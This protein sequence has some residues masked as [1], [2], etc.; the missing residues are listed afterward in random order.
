MRRKHWLVILL[1]LLVLLPAGL[2]VTRNQW[3][4]FALKHVVLSRSHGQ[5]ALD[6]GQ[7]EVGV[8]SR[9]L[10]V[11][12]PKLRF[13]NVYFNKKVGTT[14]DQVTFQRLVLTNISLFDAVMHRQFFIEH[15]LLEKPAFILG[16][17]KGKTS[18]E[19]PSG[20]NPAVLIEAMQNHQMGHLHFAFLIQHTHIRFGRIQLNAKKSSD[21]HGHASYDISIENMGTVRKPGDTLHPLF[22]D[23]LELVVRDFHRFSVP[24]RLDIALDSA[25]YSTK[26]R[27]LFLNGLHIGLLNKNVKK[28]PV[29]SVLLRWAVIKGLETG[30]AKSGQKPFLRLDKCKVVGGE[31]V[32]HPGNRRPGKKNTPKW[33]K[34]LLASYH[35]LAVDT[36]DLRHLHIL[37]TDDKGDTT[38]A[39]RRLNFTLWKVWTDKQILKTF[40]PALHFGGMQT[41]LE[42]L[43]YGNRKSP[44]RMKSGKVFYDSRH[45]V[46]TVNG[47]RVV[48]RCADDSTL[49]SFYGAEKVQVGDLSAGMLQ[50]NQYQRLSVT[51]QTP[52]AKITSDTSCISLGPGFPGILKPLA[53]TRL[54]IQNGNFD[55]EKRRNYALGINGLTLFVDSLSGSK[56]TGPDA[57]LH[58]DSLFLAA[59]RSYF[60]S[61]S[62]NESFIT[63]NLHL[64]KK[65][66]KMAA[67][68][69]VR[70]DSTGYDSLRA[71]HVTFT[72]LRLNPLFFGRELHA[73]G[74]WFYQVDY[75]SSKQNKRDLSDAMIRK[76]WND[77][78]PV[79]LKTHIGY[80]RIQ[81]SRFSLASRS[82]K[83][84]L[85][86]NSQVD[87]KVRGFKMGYDTAHLISVPGHWQAVFK[88]MK[89]GKGKWSVSSD[90]VRLN[91]DSGTLTLQA[92]KLLRRADT[93]LQF[94]V[95]IPAVSFRSVRFA[96]LFCSD[97]LVFGNVVVRSPEGNVHFIDFV[98]DTTEKKLRR[99]FFVY[100]SIRI[101]NAQIS[102]Q[103][104]KKGEHSEWHISD[105]NLLYHPGM[106]QTDY[107]EKTRRNLIQRWDISIRQL[108]FSDRNRNYKM[109]ADRI[110]LQSNQN[111]FYVRKVIGTNFSPAMV[112]TDNKQVFTYFML[113]NMSLNQMTLDG[114]KSRFL[115]VKYWDMPSVWVNII[116]N[117]DT[118]KRKSLDFL[119]AGFFDKYTRF[120]GGIHVDSSVF[121][122]VNVSYQYQRMSKL[123]NIEQL[124][125]HTRDIQLGRPFLPGTS[126][127]L[128]GEMFINL[129][130]RAI[131]SG[132]SLYTFRMGDV[133]INLPQRRIVFDSITLTPRFNRD[134]FFRRIGY[135]ADRITLYGKNAVLDN[136]RSADLLNGHF[137]HF[138]TLQVNNMSLRFERDKHYPRREA[139][140]PMLIGLINRIPY[141]FRIDSVQLNNNM[142]SYFEYEVKSKNPAIFFIDNFNVLAQNVTNHLLPADSNLILKIK[143]SGKLMKQANLDFTFVT[144][145]FARRGQWW[146]SAEAGK[147]DLTQFN[148]LT[149]NALGIS[150]ISGSGSLKVPMITGDN[151]S[152]R[153]YVDFL[154]HKLKLRLYN[155]KKS[156]KSKSF[157]SPFANFM[158]NSIIVNSNNPPFLGHVKKGIVYYERDP[159]K[160]FVNYLWKSNLSGILSTIGFNNKQ[161]REVK[162][163][164][165]KETKATENDRKAAVKKAKKK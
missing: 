131:I 71:G 34:S 120:L 84:N 165:K 118:T 85:T 70:T 8:F 82:P 164:D 73:W 134:A 158:M 27:K 39:L 51:L 3:V 144:P 149:E 62:K 13:R 147:I 40:L 151:I 54:K 138:G 92:M 75:R 136:F 37:Q 103:I 108:I 160:S 80:L 86:V 67:V 46:L 98:S 139:V 43:K 117:D 7:I 126:N 60:T 72:R 26:D 28:S 10:T 162:R 30:K 44:V 141:R 133:R 161:Q 93:G 83:G 47:F 154:Y 101:G 96:P 105:L 159:Q 5:I 59:H 113:T 29:A 132:D 21:V 63:G 143:G 95:R 114:R 155:R 104:D 55:Y 18:S 110:A 142:I 124:A 100:D 125:V 111:R 112:D 64:D 76:H 41:S 97:S 20:F 4:A 1:V 35:I 69:F 137:L 17:T 56:F 24:E 42:R 15:L 19:K 48:R 87:L 145:Y 102:L 81:K 32:L 123:V 65:I 66:F 58:F 23:N 146:F 78:V 33:L 61:F 57:A 89:I 140:K 49:V 122:N 74:A 163:E 38:L 9:T 6:F 157:I 152:A 77:F 90:R 25:F 45:R 50:R 148:P 68:R 31:V 99:W 153:G 121:G 109:V 52:F 22:F 14:L 11:E 119:N 156:E 130:D 88:K 79:P 135:Q 127:A 12:K 150:I 2:Y 106:L 94:N 91:S 107:F 128:F 116:S 115:H 53:V 16:K 36:L 129:N